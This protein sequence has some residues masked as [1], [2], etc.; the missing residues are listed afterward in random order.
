M[1]QKTLQWILL[2]STGRVPLIACR[3][4]M[5]KGVRHGSGWCSVGDTQ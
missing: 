2:N 3:M 5:G 4:R 1:I